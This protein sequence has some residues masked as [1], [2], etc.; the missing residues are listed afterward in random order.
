MRSQANRTRL[1]LHLRLFFAL[2]TFAALTAMHSVA[3]A[4]V[5]IDSSSRTTTMSHPASPGVV[6]PRADMAALITP[7]VAPAAP[8][9]VQALAPG[10]DVPM[11][12][13][14]NHVVAT[15]AA[16]LTSLLVL[17]LLFLVR[18]WER[19][20]DVAAQ[21]TSILTVLGTSLFRPPDLSLLQ[22]SR[23]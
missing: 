1:S 10:S 2:L 12:S 3:A 19:L 16:I 15:C 4:P 18:P 13:H 21:K 5:A 6:A 14:G 9:I 20:R 8:E 17:A 22:L 7:M 23:T 11:P